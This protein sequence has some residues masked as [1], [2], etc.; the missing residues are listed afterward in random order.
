MYNWVAY[1]ETKEGQ[2]RVVRVIAEDL[3]TAKIK[4]MF[5]S[6]VTDKFLKIDQGEPVKEKPQWIK[7]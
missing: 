7:R 4:A 5:A 6:K 3:E 1:Y 2:E